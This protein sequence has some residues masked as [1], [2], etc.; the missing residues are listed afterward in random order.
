MFPLVV[1]EDAATVALFHFRWSRSGSGRGM[2]WDY[3]QV[4]ALC[5]R[6]R[7]LPQLRSTDRTHRLTTPQS[8]CV[9]GILCN[10]DGVDKDRSG[11]LVAPR[12]SPLNDAVPRLL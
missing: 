12:S 4:S 9:P 6:K 2:H 7:Q 5:F 11:R 8:D 1:C 3:A 10:A